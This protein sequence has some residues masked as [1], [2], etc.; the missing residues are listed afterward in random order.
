M[1]LHEQI[2]AVLQAKL[3]G[4]QGVAIDDVKA[5]EIQAILQDTLAGFYVY[6]AATG[7]FWINA[8][9]AQVHDVLPEA[10]APFA[11]EMSPI[12]SVDQL[13]FHLR[14]VA[15]FRIPDEGT[16]EVAD[17]T[18]AHDHIGRSAAA[19]ADGG[20]AGH[21]DDAG[22]LHTLVGPDV[23]VS[24]GSLGNLREDAKPDPQLAPKRKRRFNLLD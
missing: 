16:S 4:Y 8:S 1:R 11:L 12:I 19:S 23:A 2:A 20:D 17:D 21:G 13:R 18:P 7:F 24:G 3:A 22:T 5:G 6:D 14:Q 10:M 15:P 9:L